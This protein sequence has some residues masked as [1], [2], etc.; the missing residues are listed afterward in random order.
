MIRRALTLVVSTAVVSVAF[1][2]PALALYREDGDEPGTGLSVL[3]TLGYFVGAP[4]LLYV[5]ISLLV[6]GSTSKRGAGV[7]DLDRIP[8]SD[9]D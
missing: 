7:A 8:L 2:S 5:V 3:E 1:V 4:V 6:M 9:R